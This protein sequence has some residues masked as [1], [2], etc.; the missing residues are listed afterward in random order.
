MTSKLKATLSLAALALLSACA[1]A[2]APHADLAPTPPTPLDQYPLTAQSMVKTINLRIEPEGL[3]P[4]Q[5]AAL[6]Q[7]ASQ[8]SWMNGQPADVQIITSGDP[9][10]VNAGHGVGDYLLGH[11]VAVENI[12]QSSADDQPGDVISVNLVYYRAKTYDC[13]QSWENLSATGSNKAYANFGCAIASNLA[14]QIADP[15]D[16]SQPVTQTSGDASRKSV[17]LDKYRKGD[18][19]SSQTDTEAKG[20]IS[21]AIK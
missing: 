21:D 12:S 9:G 1:T 8:A 13:N 11:S 2:P 7:V 4:N 15:R 3:S 17:I 5:R 6:D 10:A 19:T 14:A 16:L 18:I 20:T